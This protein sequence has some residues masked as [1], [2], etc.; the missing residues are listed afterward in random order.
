MFGVILVNCSSD[1]NKGDI[2]GYINSFIQ[3]IKSK[4]Y[5]I[6]GKKLF[7]KSIAYNMRLALIIWFA[8]LTIIGIPIIYVSIAYK[9]MCIGYT[10]SS[11][12]ATL[13][14]SKG[15]VFSLSTIFSI[16]MAFGLFF[17]SFLEYYF[18]TVFFSDIMINF[19]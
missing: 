11:I 19:V 5:A 14:K 15:I 10:I 1:E 12:V 18:T 17:A 4:E 6:D 3:S 13:G 2:T 7:L 9:G 8:G 16:F